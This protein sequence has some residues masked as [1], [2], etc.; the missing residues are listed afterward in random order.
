MEDSKQGLQK[1]WQQF[2]LLVIVNAFVGG[3]LGLER[4][5]LP[6]LGEELL[7]STTSSFLLSFIVAFGIS[8]AL[9]NYLMGKAANRIGRKRLLIIGWLF[10]IPVPFLLIYASSW[11]WVIFANILLGI[12]QGLAWS[13]TVIMKI[14]LVG[15]KDRGLAMGINEF[16]GYLAIAI[17]TFLTAQIATSYGLRPYPFY[18]G[19]IFIFFGLLL[20]IF[21]VKDTGHFVK[22]E[23]SKNKS[24]KIDDLFLQTTILDRNLGSVT[25]AGFVNNLNDG[26]F[27]GLMPILLASRGFSLPQIG[28]ITAIYPA[29]WGLGQLV[30]GKFADIYKHKTLLTIGMLIQAIALFGLVFTQHFYSSILLAMILGWGT[31]MVYPVFLVVIADKAPVAQRAESIGIFRLW[32]DFGYAAGAILTGLIADWFNFDYALITVAILTLFSGF[33]IMRRME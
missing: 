33:V 32:R 8:K 5:I 28:I 17:T 31:A 27:W 7:G 30:T 25:Q 1:N 9:A 6:M 2:T 19:I 11:S 3:M 23:V 24:K 16:A 18:L 21:V 26:M 22:K 4:S 12:N 14:D 20:S 15:D 10:A 13:S 29:V